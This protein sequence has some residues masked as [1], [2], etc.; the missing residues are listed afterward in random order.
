MAPFTPMAAAAAMAAA[1]RDCRVRTNKAERASGTRVQRQGAPPI[2][3]GGTIALELTSPSRGSMIARHEYSRTPT[4]PSIR[5]R[6]PT[7]IGGQPAG[8]TLGS[9]SAAAKGIDMHD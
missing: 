4:R 6:C 3:I 1:A 2:V 7:A 5:P 8:T 9:L